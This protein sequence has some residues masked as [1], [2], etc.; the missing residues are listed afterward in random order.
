MA[1]KMVVIVYLKSLVKAGRLGAKQEQAGTSTRK[2]EEGNRK[3]E[4]QDIIFSKEK[5]MGIITLNRRLTNVLRYETYAELYKAA[6][7]VS[8][9][10]EIRPVILTGSGERAFCAGADVQA[11]NELGTSVFNIKEYASNAG[12]A[13]R[14]VKELEI[15]VIGAANGI[16]LG[17]DRSF[18]AYA[19]S[20]LLQKKPVLGCPR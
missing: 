9:D 13:M 4:F 15:P 18:S 12:M 6:E 8:A 10:E 2:N 1:P 14:R 7:L 19:I 11:F 17:G 20:G 16:A 5:N 3:M